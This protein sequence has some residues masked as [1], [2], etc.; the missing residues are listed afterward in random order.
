MVPNG[1]GLQCQTSGSYR[2][3]RVLGR[4]GTGAVFLGHQ[5]RE[6][7]ALV[8]RTG[9]IPAEVPEQVAIEVLAPP[10]QLGEAERGDLLARCRRRAQALLTLHH[11]LAYHLFARP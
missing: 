4:G 3:D 10:I 7:P 1:A 9:A 11:P 5:V 8:E 2:R 6:T